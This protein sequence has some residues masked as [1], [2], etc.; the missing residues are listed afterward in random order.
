MNIKK[1]KNAF[2]VADVVL[3]K[4]HKVRRIKFIFLN[5][6]FDENGKK[7][8]KEI[9]KDNAGRI[10]LIVINRK[11]MKIG[12]SKARG[13]IKATMSFYQGG[14]QGGPSIRT[15]GIHIL[16]KEELEKGKKAE[17][18]MI[19][20]K[21]TKLI[22]KGLF[23]EEK[24]DVSP[25]ILDIEFKCKQ[26]YKN[27]EGKYPSWNFQENNETWRQDILKALNEHDRKRKSLN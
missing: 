22:V 10:Y 9:L 16:L 3:D 26:D 4:K 19:P 14:M 11:I 13:G 12:K 25:D 20:S 27:E 15:F 1:V 7:L 2:K 18:F 24:I 8:S 17:I 21:K 5:D 23:D 6:I